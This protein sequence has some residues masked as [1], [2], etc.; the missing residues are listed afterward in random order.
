MEMLLMAFINPSKNKNLK[1]DLF[2]FCEVDFYLWRNWTLRF[3]RKDLIHVYRF[4][5][6]MNRCLFLTMVNIPSNKNKKTKWN[7]RRSRNFWRIMGPI[8]RFC[9]SNRE[10]WWWISIHVVIFWK[11]AIWIVSFKSIFFE[12]FSQKSNKYFL[13]SF[14]FE[15]KNIHFR[16][17]M[18]FLTHSIV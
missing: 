2:I 4:V 1:S 17:E 15:G 16:C 18:V 7:N 6:L 3:L 11:I 12:S 8:I 9:A 10:M 14:H 5:R 13:Q